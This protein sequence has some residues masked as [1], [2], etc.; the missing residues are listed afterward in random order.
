M[1]LQEGM[2]NRFK[3]INKSYQQPYNKIIIHNLRF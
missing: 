2:H 1:S 3:L